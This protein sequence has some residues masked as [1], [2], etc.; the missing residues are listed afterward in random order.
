MWL[1][2]QLLAAGDW[3]KE[4][5]RVGTPKRCQDQGR[6]LEVEAGAAPVSSSQSWTSSRYLAKVE[7]V[8]GCC[9][10]KG[11]NSQYFDLCEHSRPPVAL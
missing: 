1:M 3:S 11:G 2:E 6:F 5:K 8:S 7:A 4:W 9:R 10:L